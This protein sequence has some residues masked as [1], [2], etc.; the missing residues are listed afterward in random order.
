VS[1]HPEFSEAVEVPAGFPGRALPVP[2]PEKN[3]LYIKLRD[4]PAVINAA[5]LV[6][7]ELPATPAAQTEA[8]PSA[9]AS[10]E[11]REELVGDSA[12]GL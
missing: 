7:E 12:T 9:A 10:E 8:P 1:G 6:A 3:K 4:D 11:Q 5:A 2:H